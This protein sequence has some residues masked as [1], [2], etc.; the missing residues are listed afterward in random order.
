M[1][2]N[3]AIE[4]YDT[5]LRDGTQGEKI[6]LSVQDKLLIAEKLDEFGVDYIEGGWPSSNPKDEEFFRK[7]LDLKLKNA[8]VS[9]FGSTARKPGS[10]ADDPNLTGLLRSQTPAITIFGKTWKAHSAVGL[11]L[12]DEE[13]AELIFESVR[14]L[15]EEGRE[16][17]FDA[18]HFFDG[19]KDNPAFALKMLQA[20][21]EAGAERLVLC[22]TNGGTLPHEIY[23]IIT[24][25]S[26]STSVPL[27][28]HTHN[29]GDLAVANALSALRAGATHVQGTINGIGERCGNANLIS[30]IPNVVLKMNGRFRH[31]LQLNQLTALSKFV[32][33]ILNLPPDN[34]APFVG[35]SAFAHKGGIHV[36]AVLK[37]SSLYE[38]IDPKS[39]GNRQRVLVSELSGQSNIRY[40]ARE[41]G[42]ALPEDNAALFRTMVQRIKKLEHEGY[43]FDVAEASFELL[44]RHEMGEFQP[45][46]EVL[47]SKVHIESGKNR[48]AVDQAVMKVEVNDE[49]EL[50]AA[51]GDGP[52]NALDKALRKALR[53]F[54][55]EI[56][57][58]SLVD[59]K[60]RVLE[61]KKG[62]SAKVRVLIESSD[63][64]NTWSTVGVSTNIIDASLQ[65]LSDSINYHLFNCRTKPLET[66]REATP[67]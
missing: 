45:F 53:R 27:G 10:I 31:K 67:C 18:E 35:R 23:D 55:P 5:T 36:S 40:K 46:F 20:A 60:V 43:Q 8:R 47:E 13:N 25:I 16:V 41:L 15:K 28:I 65:A 64:E 54:Y 33:E 59:Y 62:T 30:I 48:E 21:E 38:H 49:I 58:M 22:D 32:Y 66:L 17:L 51:D 19:Y 3:N 56:R 6:N 24:Q 26:S 61:E 42:I 9:A 52:V 14:H 11:G 4:L 29:D 1:N 63:K 44:L 12:T 7:A 34:R 50:T 37:E 39:V 57:N 2:Q